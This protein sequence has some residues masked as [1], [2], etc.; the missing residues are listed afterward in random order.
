MATKATNQID[1]VDLTDGYSVVLSCDAV[2]VAGDAS[3][4][5]S[6]VTNAFSVSVTAL[7][8]SETVPC[9]VA[10]TAPTGITAGTQ[11]ISSNVVTIPF[12]TTTALSGTKTIALAV[13]ITAASVTITK[14]VSVTV[15]KTGAT[16]T[17]S[18]TFF[19]YSENANGNPMVSTPT[20]ATLYIGVYTGTSSTAPTAYGS[21]TWSRY[22]GHD[23]DDGE[24]ALLLVIT[25]SA[26]TI[27]KNTQ[28]ATTLTAHVYK[29]GAELSASEIAALGTVKWYKDGSST[30]A[31]T[32]TTFSI[33]AGDVTNK[34]T[35]VAQ[36]EG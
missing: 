11:T 34:A 7:C 9:T 14:N 26:G 23:G 8:G 16:G 5:A 24:D 32:G 36:L 21:Y 10:V 1:I 3:G 29:G 12:S 22:T 19:R 6:A 28:A 20:D 4:N 2:T 13:T 15:A 25:S 35:Y 30:A 27:F 17:S 18:Y 31:G 33:S